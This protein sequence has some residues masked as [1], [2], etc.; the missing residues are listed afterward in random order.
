MPQPST[1]RARVL[2]ETG[3]AGNPV[4]KLVRAEGKLVSCGRP[5]ECVGPIFVWEADFLG[6]SVSFL[7]CSDL[8]I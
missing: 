1:H 5:H 6:A 7:K 4:I 3:V 8:E 2:F